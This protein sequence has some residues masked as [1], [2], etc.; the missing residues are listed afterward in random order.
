M[1][2]R[3][4]LAVAAPARRRVV[5][6]SLL[7]AGA[8]GAG[9]GLMATSAWLISRAAQHPRESALALGIV[10]VQFFGLSRGVFRYFQRLVAH[11]AAFRALADLRVRVYARLEG[12]A[13][14][15]LPMMRNGDLL[16]RFVHDV[17]S[18]QDLLVR[19]ICP[20]LIAVLVAAA[21]VALAWWILPL[22]GMILLATLVLAATVVPWLT[23]W[24]ARRNEAAQASARG[25]LTATVV[26][27]VRG[28][29]ELVA[30]GAVDAQLA[31]AADIDRRLGGIA[32]Q[33]AATAG[34]G[35]GLATLLPALAM[36][37]SL[38][39]GII[40]VDAGRLDVVLL[41]VIAV[42]PLAA[43]ELAT[44]LPAATQSAARVGPALARVREVL[45]AEPVVK[46]PSQP[47]PRP[48]GAAAGTVRVRGLRCRYDDHGPWVL[49]DVDLNLAPGR[50][51]A[52]VGRSGAGKSTL[53]DVLL[54]F[55]PYQ[56][57]S[58]TVGGMEISRLSG[59]DCRGL[60]GLVAQDAHIFDSTLEANLRLARPDATLDELREALERV[61]LLDWVDE[62]PEGL[63]TAAGEG[64]GRLSGGQR[65]RLAVARA[66]L[67]RFPVLIL[68]EPGEHL[69]T[70]TADAVRADILAGARDHAVLL[71]THRLAGL[72]AVDE[73]MV[74]EHG[75]VVQRGSQGDLLGEPGPYADMWRRQARD[76]V[77]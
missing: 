38:V 74:L 30:A 35:Q 37:A 32:R 53:A 26:D 10:A 25:E 2:I 6:A 55:L 5:L 50:H 15:G 68:D 31:R 56:E 28:A 29:P 16:A 3:D 71:I 33:G 51:V 24:L 62:L 34:V 77:G 42:V 49:D 45:K 36:V 64:G 52:L 8:V 59:D 22:A 75:R 72:E 27:L 39:V 76:G 69:D 11:E 73:V 48:T 47:V 65:Q 43:F 19:V 20:F 7:G 4:A 44:G 67:A 9:I 23:G 21:T 61:Q 1:T 40:A 41:A 46:E 14:A 54:R 12:L 60:V 70:A 17:D 66:L 58:V 18:V 13:P 57:G 63:A